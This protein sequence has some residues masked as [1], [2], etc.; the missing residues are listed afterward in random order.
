[1]SQTETLIEKIDSILNLT[2][3]LTSQVKVPTH[4][5]EKYSQNR[6]PIKSEI[7]MTSPPHPSLR[8]PLT[9]QPQISK[10]SKPVDKHLLDLQ[11]SL[12]NAQNER[13][14]LQR[15]TRDRIIEL[16]NR[17]EDL[18]KRIAIKAKAVDK[19]NDRS[20]MQEKHICELG[21]KHQEEQ[22]VN[23][24]LSATFRKMKILTSEKI[25]SMEKKLSIVVNELE[26]NRDSTR[27]MKSMIDD[28]MKKV[29]EELIEYY[30]SQIQESREMNKEETKKIEEMKEE[31][32]AMEYNFKNLRAEIP[33]TSLMIERTIKEQKN[34]EFRIQK[35]EKI[36]EISELEFE[37]LRLQED[38][39]LNQNQFNI[40]QD[41]IASQ[42][43]QLKVLLGTLQ[44]EKNSINLEKE[45]QSKVLQELSQGRQQA[46]QDLIDLINNHEGE[47]VIYEQEIQKME[48]EYEAI[49][50]SNVQQLE[51]YEHHLALGIDKG[52]EIEGSIV[53]FREEIYVLEGQMKN[54]LD[55]LDGGFQKIIYNCN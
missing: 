47:K 3:E 14:D 9:S 42:R 20:L 50:E 45:I 27:Y 7:L 22:A 36:E 49:F 34:Q 38:L 1:M 16:S 2:S 51:K 31:I 19:L 8:R 30:Q 18:K 15:G 55:Q 52:K 12:K 46:E 39:D 43:Q 54:I 48:E 13:K 5:I 26:Q 41:Q 11:N 23:D 53:E 29:E 4:L 10:I 24:T 28:E 32:R 33:R 40:A 6:T 21:N 37:N 35:N 17:K 25:S 44:E